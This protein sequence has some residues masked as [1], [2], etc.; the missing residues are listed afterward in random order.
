MK[1]ENVNMNAIAA[2]ALIAKYAGQ[3]EAVGLALL[4]SAKVKAGHKDES[5]KAA[6]SVLKAVK[7]Y[8]AQTAA[9][10]VEADVAGDTL[11]LALTIAQ[12]PKGTALNYGRCVQGFRKIMETDGPGSL[13]AATQKQA[14]A[15]MESPETAVKNEKRKT[16]AGYVAKATADQLDALIAHAAELGIVP[17]APAV[18]ATT[19]TQEAVQDGADE[20]EAEGVEAVG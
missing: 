13:D 16:L 11:R 19:G 12:F 14:Q 10:G 1:V 2:N 20:G 8:T 9:D 5:D 17:K 6:G 7:D 4:S 3:I 18:K 15:I